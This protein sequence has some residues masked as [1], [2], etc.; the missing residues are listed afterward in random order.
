MKSIE[1]RDLEKKSLI[2]SRWAYQGRVVNLRLDTFQ[3]G[4]ETRV[5]EIIHHAGAVVIL[6]IDS[7]GK[8]LLIQQWRRAVNEILIELPA[9]TL[10]PGEEPRA[11]AIRELR[12]ET[13]FDARKL[14][15]LGGFFS[16]PG[17]CDE[18]L[19]LFVAEDLHPSPL[20]LT[21]MKK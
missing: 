20:P 19:H 14:T 12:E 8:I 1:Q 6:P 17:F 2:D 16:C 9:G 13:G 4:E 5:R 7:K 18:Y 11:T 15:S 10:E 21:T 3:F